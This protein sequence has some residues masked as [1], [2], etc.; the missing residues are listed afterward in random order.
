MKQESELYRTLI[1]IESRHRTPLHVHIQIQSLDILRKVIWYLLLNG[2][3][4]MEEC[5]MLLWNRI[6]I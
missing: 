2:P 1:F 6:S 3:L 5:P 4:G